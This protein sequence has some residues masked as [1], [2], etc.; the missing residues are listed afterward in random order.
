MFEIKCL[1]GDN[2]FVILVFLNYEYV[3]KVKEMF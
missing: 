1:Y 2:F 3:I